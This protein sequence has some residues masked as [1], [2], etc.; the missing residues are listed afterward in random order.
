MMKQ[1]VGA[2]DKLIRLVAG[3]AIIAAG[4]SAGAWWAALGAVPLLTA[5]GGW[6]PPYTLLG[7]NTCAE[8]REA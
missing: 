5:L 7:I 3:V 8:C 1:N 2:V 6:C 4:I